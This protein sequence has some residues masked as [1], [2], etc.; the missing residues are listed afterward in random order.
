M[1]PK[2]FFLCQGVRPEALDAVVAR[3]GITHVITS[4][5]SLRYNLTGEP[6]ALPDV[7]RGFA[8]GAHSAE[9][10]AEVLQD[11]IA[12]GPRFQALCEKRTRF[13]QANPFYTDMNSTMRIV[14]LID[15]LAV[16]G[17]R[18]DVVKP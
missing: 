4:D 10:L 7:E 17:K 3:H 8:L 9:E 2:I 18:D 15:E 6:D 12:K 11:V 14:Q 16:A 1:E 13:F 5:A